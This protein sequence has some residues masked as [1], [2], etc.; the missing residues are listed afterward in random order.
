MTDDDKDD[1][2]NSESQVVTVE[3]ETRANSLIPVASGE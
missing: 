3:K 1:E 2:C